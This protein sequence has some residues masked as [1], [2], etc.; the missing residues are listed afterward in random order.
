MSGHTFVMCCKIASLS[1]YNDFSE[2]GT[3]ACFPIRF[4][5]TKP[6]SLNSIK[7]GT[8]PRPVIVS[9][10]CS[11]V[12]FARHASTPEFSSLIS[13]HIGGSS[14]APM[15]LD[16]VIRPFNSFIVLSPFYLTPSMIVKEPIF[17]VIL[18]PGLIII[19]I[20]PIRIL[21]GTSKS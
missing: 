13:I 3:I 17:P 6:E 2:R 21:S 12:I 5:P 4:I 19:L 15:I 1:P 9:A 7:H 18:T 14:D 11:R 16:I 10:Y 20:N 8:S